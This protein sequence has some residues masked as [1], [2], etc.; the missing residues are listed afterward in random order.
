MSAFPLPGIGHIMERLVECV[1]SQGERVR[2]TGASPCRLPAVSFRWPSRSPASGRRR[3]SQLR[4]PRLARGFAS[5]GRAGVP[6]HPLP[7][8]PRGCHI[9]GRPR[10]LLALLRSRGSDERRTLGPDHRPGRVGGDAAA[11]GCEDRRGHPEVVREGGW[12]L[13]AAGD[14]RSRRDVW[15]GAGPPALA[16]GGGAIAAL[17][18]GNRHSSGQPDPRGGSPRRV[19]DRGREADDVAPSAGAAPRRGRCGAR[20]GLPPGHGAARRLR[21]GFRRRR[22]VPHRP[23]N[24]LP[25]AGDA[26]RTGRRLV[27]R[28][29]LLRTHSG[30]DGPCRRLVS[31]SAAG[32]GPQPAR[33]RRCLDHG[34]HGPLRL[35]RLHCS[36]M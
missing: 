30:H 2:Q 14:P 3:R 16:P 11:R 21:P 13:A 8:L 26:R 10:H 7:R 4:R 17:P 27:Q 12:K 35:G 33:D 22:R 36:S 9:G 29:D 31:V 24:P 20:R 18:A 34:A 19:Y 15:Q 28:H 25:G 23:H 5:A 1:R 6:P 32:V